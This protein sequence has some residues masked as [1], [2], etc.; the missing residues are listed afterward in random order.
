MTRSDEI[1]AKGVD[2]KSSIVITGASSTAK[3][4]LSVSGTFENEVSLIINPFASAHVSGDYQQTGSGTLTLYANTAGDTGA[5]TVTGALSLAGGGA[6]GGFGSALQVRSFSET[7]GTVVSVAT[8]APGQLTGM[9]GGLFNT[10]G[11]Y[12][13]LGNGTYGGVE[14][15]D[16]LGKVVFEV[17]AAPT[18]T[19]D[20]WTAGTS[21]NW[22]SANW[23]NGA[24]TFYTDA[25]LGAKAKVSLAA[26]M[27][28][29]SLTLDAGASLTQQSGHSLSIGQGL[30]V[31]AGATLTVDGEMTVGT[32]GA[33]TLPGSVIVN[34]WLEVRGI[35]SG[36]YP[37]P[38]GSFTI[39]SG[40]TLELDRLDQNNVAFSGARGTLM[41]EDPGQ[42]EGTISGFESGDRLQ[43]AGDV[44]SAS[45]NATSHELTFIDNGATINLGFI[46]ASGSSNV[47]FGLTSGGNSTTIT[48]SVVWDPSIPGE[49][50]TWNYALNWSPAV[51][52]GSSNAVTIGANFTVASDADNSAGQLS[53][54][55]G[56]T[57]TIGDD[58]TF[59]VDDALNNS[60]VIQFAGLGSLILSG[61]IV[62]S[63]EIETGSHV[64]KNLPPLDF[65]SLEGDVDIS[66]GG[67]IVLSDPADVFAA[68]VGPPSTLTLTSAIDGVGEIS[69]MNLDIAG[70]PG[71]I[72]ADG[73]VSDTTV[74]ANQYADTL[75]IDAAGPITNDNVLGATNSGVLVIKNDVENIGQFATLNADGGTIDI[76]GITV[77][78]G[79]LESEGVGGDITA[80]NATLDGSTY[81]ALT[82]TGPLRLENS[83]SSLTLA[84]SIVNDGTMA[85]TAANETLVV[86]GNVSLGLT[87][88]AFATIGTGVILESESDKVSGQ[89]SLTLASG[90]SG[91]GAITMAGGITINAGGFLLADDDDSPSAPAGAAL[92]I[93]KG[94]T[95]TN[96]GL[97]GAFGRPPATLIVE[98]NVVNVGDGE[99]AAESS[100]PGANVVISNVTITSGTIATNPYGSIE[101]D[102]STLNG[103]DIEGTV[104]LG[105]AGASLT[106]EGAIG[107]NT[108]DN[109]LNGTINF[110]AK[111]QTLVINGSVSV[112]GPGEIN[113]IDADDLVESKGTFTKVANSPSSLTLDSEI[114]GEGTIGDAQLTLS[115]GQQGQIVAKGPNALILNT[116][117][118]TI[119][120]AGTLESDGGELVID[121]NVKNAGG[122][123]AADSEDV[124]ISGVTISG[125]AF[126]GHIFVAATLLETGSVLDGSSQGALTNDGALQI[127]KTQSTVTLEGAIDN[128]GI[129]SFNSQTQSLLVASAVTL[130]GGGLIFMNDSTDKILS[131]GHAATLSSS[132]QITGVGVIGDADTTL[133]VS[134]GGSIIADPSHDLTPTSGDT[135]TITTGA[136]AIINQGALEAQNGGVLKISNDINNASGAVEANG[137]LSIVALNGVAVAGGTLSTSASGVI[138]ADDNLTLDGAS[139]GAMTDNATVDL[140]TKSATLTLTGVIANAGTLDLAAQ[141]QKVILSGNLTLTGAGSVLLGDSGDTLVDNGSATTLTIDNTVAGVG[142]IGDSKLTLTISQ[143]GAIVATP[144]Y[145]VTTV[146]GNKLTIGALAAGNRQRRRT[147]GRGWRRAGRQGRGDGHGRRNHQ[148][149]TSRTRRRLFAANPVHH[150]RCRRAADRRRHRIRQRHTRL[151]HRRYDQSIEGGLRRQRQRDARSGQCPA[152]GREWNDL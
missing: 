123:I 147:F 91:I 115:V 148:R 39:G 57:L 25:T 27:T 62:N 134:S 10:G 105:T 44:T 120:N 83:G 74:A 13:N 136:N 22:G 12:L 141:K 60:G 5:L 76:D 16:S 63:G 99:I 66:G 92:T 19:A 98:D 77:F 122:T 85:L 112:S 93:A 20:A 1:T 138:E 108:D 116:G 110:N 49:P 82:N 72:I 151:H 69:G 73:S 113:L 75:T 139:R 18:T 125:G 48:S 9:F 119:A 117:A 51:V 129:I 121:S 78:G 137:A 86:D 67:K 59:T 46:P 21:G 3:G 128:A 95:I 58:T 31:A 102:N 38:N 54:G 65:I 150:G 101:A 79:L 87:S 55:Q 118:K 47:Q 35:A 143:G 52:P 96:S 94:G 100:V 28:L 130:S 11:T 135:L 50:P 90:L 53:L 80:D 142:A 106:L 17:V 124:E 42:F 26:D 146:S 43:V 140:E 8:F 71:S 29:D 7:V 34:G 88:G 104:N 111:S 126:A 109:I 103:V 36:G 152:S 40:G 149:R 30:A 64:V 132:N 24:P 2:N 68:H 15:E 114:A 144:A 56:A 41:L 84:G 61:S 23:S 97:L 131:N 4:T 32:S 37:T 89:A 70:G 81:G 14:Y 45:Y 107:L 33:D 133:T 145:D 127:D 6:A